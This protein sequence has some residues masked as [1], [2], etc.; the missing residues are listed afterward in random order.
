MSRSSDSSFSDSLFYPI[1]ERHGRR[2]T[3]IVS[4]P[5]GL[6]RAPNTQ[7]GRIAIVY[8]Q[9]AEAYEYR[10][11][12]EFLQSLGYLTA[13]VEDLDLVELAVSLLAWDSAAINVAL[14]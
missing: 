9:S 3:N 6:A 4:I 7:P 1:V 13:E 12:I 10:G 2:S 5:W 14:S 11:Y 8:S